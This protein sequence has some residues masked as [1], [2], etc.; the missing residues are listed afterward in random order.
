[1]RLTPN[2]EAALAELEWELSA[3]H[4]LDEIAERLGKSRRTVQRIE[5]RALAKM[6]DGAQKGEW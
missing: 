6:R 1:V 2:E 3:P 4:T 5:Q